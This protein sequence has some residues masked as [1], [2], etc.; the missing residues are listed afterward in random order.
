[1]FKKE[2]KQ[3]YFIILFMS[4][5]VLVSILRALPAFNY[6]AHYID[7]EYIVY[8]AVGFLGYDFNP[9]LFVYHTLPMY[10]LSFIYFI[11]Y[12]L[13]YIVGLVSSKIE[14]I[15]LLFQDDSI[16]FISANLLF[17][18]VYTL[19]CFVLSLIVYKHFTSKIGAVIF[20]LVTLLPSDSYAASTIAR[21]DNFVFLFLTLTIY[22]CCFAPKKFSSFMLSVIFCCAAFT[23]KFPAIVF[24]PIL[25]IKIVHDIYEGNYP[26]KYLIYFFIT[27]PIITFLF[28]PY[29]FL[30]FSSYKSVLTLV[31]ARS[32][33]TFSWVGHVQYDNTWQK[34]YRLYELLISQSGILSVIGTCLFVLYSLIWNKKMIFPWLFVSTYIASFSTSSIISDWWLR[35]VYPFFIFFTV[36]LLTRL[37][38][39]EIV[40]NHIKKPLLYKHIN[41]I[42]FINKYII[43]FM[44]AGYYIFIFQ[45]SLSKYY[46]SLEKRD[47]TRVISNVWIQKYIPENATI[48]LD[49][50]VNYLPNVFSNDKKTNQIITAVFRMGRQKNEILN[51]GFE[52][53]FS[54]YYGKYI[55]YNI[56]LLR[57]TAFSENLKLINK[58]DYIVISSMSYDRFFKKHT[59][60]KFPQRTKEAIEYYS[61]IKKQKHIISFKGRGPIISIY[62]MQTN[63]EELR[64]TLIKKISEGL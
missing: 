25:F 10:I 2:S 37:K 7:E 47:D 23:S 20:L 49:G 22:F 1:M 38:N 30:D 42:L 63:G 6:S 51:K 53:Y 50:I 28:M 43:Y 14:F 40:Y 15:S 59:M 5:L 55:N 60:D 45:G 19:G 27:I 44:I 62:Q 4:V 61:L 16:Y 3:Y 36:V 17:G 29:M 35:P 48:L 21:V 54:K 18:F 56:R 31:I 32:S 46:Y 64:E 52:F 26:K 24:F 8:P 57:Y 58:D 34:L 33:G 39:M 9:R 13:Y 41:N 12:A 11:I